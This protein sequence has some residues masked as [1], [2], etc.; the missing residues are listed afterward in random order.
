MAQYFKGG[1]K[2][3]VGKSM[4]IYIFFQHFSDIFDQNNNSL[5]AIP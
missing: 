1:Q 2:L 4:I 3:V 5:I